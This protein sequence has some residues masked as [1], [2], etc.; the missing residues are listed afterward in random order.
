[1]AA[2]KANELENETDGELVSAEKSGK[3]EKNSGKNGDNPDNPADKKADQKSEKRAEL[4]K[5]ENEIKSRKA[6]NEKKPKKSVRKFFR[7]TKSEFKKVAW[8]PAKQVWKLTAVVLVVIVITATAIFGLDS[9]F[10]QLLRL[11]LKMD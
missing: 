5:R 8:L 2:E 9:L 1:M 4:A 6:A 10:N 7:D 3:S 11:L